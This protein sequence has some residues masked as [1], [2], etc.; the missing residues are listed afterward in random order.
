[1]R[2]SSTNSSFA[3]QFALLSSLNVIVGFAVLMYSAPR[4]D[5][6]AGSLKHQLEAYQK[7]YDWNR[8]PPR[9]DKPVDIDE[10]DPTN[11]WDLVQE[12]RHC[13][14]LDKPADWLPLAPA[15]HTDEYPWSCC[16]NRES[17]MQTGKCTSKMDVWHDGCRDT[18]IAADNYLI[19][20]ITALV[21]LNLM[22]SV[23]ACLVLCC[24]QRTSTDGH[25][26]S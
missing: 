23:M 1:M 4:L 5:D 2:D 14:G 20:L 9:V 7:K 19:L 11:K 6:T 10:T 25:Y 18:I 13:C 22:L 3:M 26:Y 16:V 17:V 8:G 21:Y 15:N 24:Q 12:Y